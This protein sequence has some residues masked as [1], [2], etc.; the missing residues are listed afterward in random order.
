VARLPSP[1]L[2]PAQFATADF[3]STYRRQGGVERRPDN[4]GVFRLFCLSAD[5]RLGYIL[6]LQNGGEERCVNCRETASDHHHRLPWITLYR[7]GFIRW[8]F[9]RQTDVTARRRPAL[10][11][12][13]NNKFQVRGP[14]YFALV[15]VGS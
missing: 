6:R 8:F 4:F 13:P 2:P 9:N 11:V 14:F 12:A 1:P 10:E 3:K 7:K 15:I 5:N